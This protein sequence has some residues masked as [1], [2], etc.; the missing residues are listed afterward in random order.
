MFLKFISL[1][2]V[3]T[4]KQIADCF[5]SMLVEENILYSTAQNIDEDIEPS[6]KRINYL[7]IHWCCALPIV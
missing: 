6:N 3:H 7:L 5:K 1:C 2:I 4:L